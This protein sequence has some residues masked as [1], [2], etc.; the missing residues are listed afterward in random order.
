L[1]KAKSIS[2]IKDV[3]DINMDQ[4]VLSNM[5]SNIMALTKGKIDE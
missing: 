5:V 1:E 2:D 3:K 4:Y